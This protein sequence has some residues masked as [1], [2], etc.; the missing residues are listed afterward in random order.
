MKTT[1]LIL[2]YVLIH[3]FCFSQDLRGIWQGYI[4]AKGLLNRSEYTLNIKSQNNGVISGKAY[5]FSTKL[6]IFQGEFDFI[7]RFGAF[8]DLKI[9]ELKILNKSLPSD[10]FEL[11]I[12]FESL[13]YSK[14]TSEYLRGAWG[15]TKGNCPP[16]DVYLKR[17]IPNKSNTVKIPEAVYSKILEDTQPNITFQGTV[18][19]KPTILDVRQVTLE[20]S[21][22]DYLQ[23]D[24]DTVSV[25]LNRQEIIKDHLI[26]HKPYTKKVKLD[27]LSGLNE[28]IVYAKNLGRIPPNTCTLIVSDGYKRQKVSILSDKQNSAAIYLNYVIPPE[29]IYQSY[30]SVKDAALINSPAVIK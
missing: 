19:S 24:F 11:C 10:L 4:T 23:E 20:I 17:V 29:Y 7:G 13:V 22:K 27:V 3:S 28:I 15:N 25:Y 6:F 18:L 26:S 21:L 2:I 1:A 14:D 8:K 9:T 16:G 30:E 5:L 12:K